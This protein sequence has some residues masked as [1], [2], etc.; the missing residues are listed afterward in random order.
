MS[1]LFKVTASVGMKGQGTPF[2]DWLAE[3]NLVTNRKSRNEVH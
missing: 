2:K 3:N 1:G